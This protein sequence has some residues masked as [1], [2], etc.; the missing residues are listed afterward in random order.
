[1]STSI[2]MDIQLTVCPYGQTTDFN[3]L[4]LA[5]VFHKDRYNSPNNFL[6]WSTFQISSYPSYWHVWLSVSTY[7]LTEWLSFPPPSKCWPPVYITHSCHTNIFSKRENRKF[8]KWFLSVF[9]SFSFSSFLKEKQISF[10]T[11][12]FPPTFTFLT[13][14]TFL[15]GF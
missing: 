3:A 9:L 11:L 2:F 13:L 5:I 8:C 4:I 1:M 6:C 14:F 7:R 10:F 15:F 12:L